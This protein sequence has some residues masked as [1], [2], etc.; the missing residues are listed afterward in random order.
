MREYAEGAERAPLGLGGVGQEPQ[1][2]VGM[3]GDDHRVETL[4]YAIG[5]RRCDP[6]RSRA[7]VHGPDRGARRHGSHP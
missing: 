3:G 7:G 4:V 2:G 6:S 5:G 1:G